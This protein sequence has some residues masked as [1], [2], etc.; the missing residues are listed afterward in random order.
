MTPERPVGTVVW[1][2]LFLPQATTVPDW[3]PAGELVGPGVTTATVGVAG[4]IVAAAVG[5]GMVE[6]AGVPPALAVDVAPLPE[7]AASVAI[8][9]PIRDA[10]TILGMTVACAIIWDS[11]WDASGAIAVRR[12]RGEHRHAVLFVTEASRAV[13][14]DVGFGFLNPIPISGR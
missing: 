12:R 4:A 1:L 7:Q 10:L 11:L 14:R 13:A 9:P 2:V 6:V 3:G 5:V 8:S